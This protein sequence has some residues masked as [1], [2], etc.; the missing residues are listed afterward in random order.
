M[1]K[2]LVIGGGAA[3]MMA[4]IAAADGSHDVTL[5]ERNEKLGKKLLITGKGRCNVTN[6]CESERFFDAVVT[7][8]RFLYSAYRQFDNQDMMA[9]LED[10]GCALKTER[11]NRVFPVSDHSAD[12]LSAL[13][14]LLR[15]KKV[16]VRLHCRIKELVLA[17]NDNSSQPQDV[18]KHT[19]AL[20]IQGVLLENGETLFADAVILATGGMSYPATG[21]T[22][23]GLQLAE[24]CGHTLAPCTPA[25]VPLTVKEDWCMQLQGLT[26]KNVT[27]T[28]FEGEKERYQGFGEMLFTHFGV[29]GPLVLTA[30]SFYEKMAD[31]KN[32]RLLIDVKPALSKE[33]LD[34]RIRRDFS[35]NANRQ[36]KNALS[37]LFPNKLIPVMVTL[38]AIPPEKAV[39]D[40]TRAERLR[41][42]E[43]CKN[44]PLTVTGTRGFAEAIITQG[45]V[46]VADI[47]PSTMESKKVQGL[48]FAGEMIDTDALTGGYNLQI[49]WSTGYLAGVNAAKKYQKI[50]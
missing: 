15:K 24:K 34:E 13:E 31:K 28:L 6:A 17:S 33:Q 4:A 21:S 32:V 2:I 30:A 12:V 38:S 26:L 36:F 48:Y 50:Q 10:A 23:D 45:G 43:L 27:L 46:S 49:A 44:L 35:E 37:G 11:G 29:S 40:I 47:N 18:S 7:N 1:A 16:R 9:L 41:L 5:L 20:R 14:R 19:P 42:L 8:P 39:H 25:L 3:G 22:G